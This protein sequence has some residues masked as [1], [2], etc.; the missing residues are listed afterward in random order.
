MK[1]K[2]LQLAQLHHLNKNQ[3]KIL[4]IITIIMMINRMII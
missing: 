4:I 3:N 1:K 2:K